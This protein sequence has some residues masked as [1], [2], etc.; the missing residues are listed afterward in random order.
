LW[1]QIDPSTL[2]LV[3]DLTDWNVAVPLSFVPLAV[4]WWSTW[5]P[6]SEPGAG[7]DLAVAQSER[8]AM[9]GTCCAGNDWLCLGDGRVQRRTAPVPHRGLSPGHH[10]QT[11]CE[12]QTELSAPTVCAIHAPTPYSLTRGLTEWLLLFAR[13][14]TGRS[15]LSI[16]SIKA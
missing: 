8:D 15:K 11:H 9:A 3:P 1:L 10:R 6:E 2:A 5:Y 12:S 4:Q 14:L 16:E 13:V 7:S